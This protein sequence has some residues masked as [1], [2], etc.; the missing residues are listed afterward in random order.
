MMASN[1]RGRE[2]LVEM[3]DISGFKE[4]VENE[5]ERAVEEMCNL[6]RG[7]G[8]RRILPNRMSSMGGTDKYLGKEETK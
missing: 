3:P 1:M 5:I 2:N 6:C 4:R 8:N 7:S